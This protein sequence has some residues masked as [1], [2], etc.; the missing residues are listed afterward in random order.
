[1]LN[2]WESEADWEDEA[3]EMKH[4]RGGKGNFV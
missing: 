1:M 4:R 2:E 3:M